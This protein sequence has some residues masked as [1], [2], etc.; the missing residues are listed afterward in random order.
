[1]PDVTD[2]KI[3]IYNHL[4]QE[5]RVLQNGIMQ[6]GEHSVVWD[7]SNKHGQPVSAGVYLFNID[8]G[9]FNK[10]QKIILLK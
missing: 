6:P 7:S 4:G 3:T 5:V 10:T 8:A 2:I 1:M 9:V